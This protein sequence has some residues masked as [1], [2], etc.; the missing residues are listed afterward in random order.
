M[1]LGLGALILILHLPALANAAEPEEGSQ[2]QDTPL[3]GLAS[4]PLGC[5]AVG[6]D[7]P[8]E[9]PGLGRA[10]GTVKLAW[11]GQVER[12]RLILSVSGA[13]A[14]HTIMVNGQPVA[15]API[16]P[17]GQPCQ[18]GESFYLD[19]P[20]A[21][22][23]QGDNLIEIGDDAL[24]GDSWTAAQVRLEVLGHFSVLRPA[25]IGAM[26]AISYT[27][28]FVNPYDASAQQV[29]VV[30][31]GSYSGGTP[32]PLVI[33]VHG[34]SSSM[35]EG[36][37][38]LG[39][40][41][42]GKGWLLA[43]PELHGSWTGNPQPDP[44]GKYAYASLES[45]YDIVGAASYM[46]DHYSVLTDRIYLVGYS[47]GG[48]IATVTAAKFP[49]VFAAVFDNKGP[50]DMARWYGEQW[51]QEWME[52]ECN[53]GGIPQN[54]AQNPFCYQ[55]R[56][57]Q[58]FAGNYVHI[59]LSI[60][61][62]VSDA[63]VPI[64]HS[65]DLRDK[66]NAYSPDFPVSV[67][68]DTVI[69]PTCD[70]GGRY[71]CYEP[72]PA[73]VLNY[74]QPFTLSDDPHS[75]RI[76]SDESKSYYWLNLAQTG[77]DHWSQIVVSSYP[78]SSTVLAVVSDTYPLS[79]AFNLGSTP[80]T[81]LVLSQ[82]G[83]GLPSTTYL[84]KGGGNNDL[85]DYVSGY[86]T[87]SL[88]STGQF[89]LTVSAIRTQVSAQPPMA[90]G[91][92]TATSTITVLA[93][94][95][96]DNPVPDG[97]TVRLSATKGT[98]PNQ[99]ST[100]T[101]T[102]AGG[103]VSTALTLAPYGDRAQVTANIGG[104]SASTWIEVI[105]PSLAIAAMPDRAV[106]DQGLAVTC[107][108]WITNTGDTALAAITLID[109]SGTPGHLA[110]DVVVCTNTALPAWTSMQC[111]HSRI[112]AQTTISTATV[113]GQDPLGNVVSSSD[114]TVVTVR[115]RVYLPLVDRRE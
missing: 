31:P 80:I 51:E 75:I 63:L 69:G 21:A 93:G 37:E 84:V 10:S 81:G 110:D 25:D 64:H 13:E 87:V 39:T 33:Y 72:S 109:D 79:I 22:L 18:K 49:H 76:T 61:H 1:V 115:Q 42:D 6:R 2:R 100:Y 91:W 60:T 105:Y 99:S 102:A 3:V 50:T 16:Y 114:V 112:L 17:D 88:H 82:P 94:D 113:T 32:V 106:I 96:L 68:E 111:S 29:R 46:L 23:V 67:Y 66:I 15:R 65:R 89:T 95:S 38:T 11:H 92:Q 27:A 101:T 104:I 53:I 62:S 71:H 73:A 47:M 24:P 54:P 57:G 90:S 55:R 44:P 83:M 103:R 8:G 28:S 58:S 107:S 70:D 74:L 97:T 26:A 14:A 78:N 45:Q 30:V 48:Q 5:L 35:Y 98:F 52:R 43:T 108:Y 20:P 86:M 36:E 59:P 85:R 77:G 40:A 4:D 7:M 19:I 56:S 34:R 9:A 12:A 41:V